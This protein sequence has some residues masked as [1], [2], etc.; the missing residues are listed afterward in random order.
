VDR[1]LE[2]IALACVAECRRQNVGL[3]RLAFLLEGYNYAVENGDRLPSE[4][5]LLHLASIVEPS[6]MGRYRVTPVTFQDGGLAAD[7]NTVPAATAR[8]FGIFEEGADPHEFVH[9]L[10]T[11][12]PFT[13]GNGRLGFILYNWLMHRLDDPLP[14]PDYSFA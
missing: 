3:D 14:L 6:T 5:D 7:A 2:Q 4:G 10:L 13:D 11:I 9:H 12:H 1:N 8:L